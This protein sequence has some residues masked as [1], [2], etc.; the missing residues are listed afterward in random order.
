[1]ADNEVRKII[2]LNKLEEEE[3]ELFGFDLSEFTT[4]QEIRRAEDPWVNQ[5]SLHL[6][7]NS[8]LQERLGSG[9]YILG[10]GENKTLRLSA[11]ARSQIKAD[12]AKLPT[13]HSA[14]RRNW[15][16]YLNGKRPTASITF[17]AEAAEKNR[18]SMFITAL[19]P[20][21]KQAALHF[22]SADTAYIKI[23]A[24]SEV[25][26]NGIYPFSVY[27]SIICGIWLLKP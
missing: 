9:L 13:S 16:N 8:Y 2:E 27:T 5:N 18:E 7:I 15:E 26:P 14:L 4:S 25:L 23:R 21:T 22:A 20:L 1:M 11:N 12:L 10:D 19:H 6:L 24:Y 17:D 3:K